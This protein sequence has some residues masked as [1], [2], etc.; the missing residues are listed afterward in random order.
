MQYYEIRIDFYRQTRQKDDFQ[1][2]IFKSI[3]FL[4]IWKAK[5]I[6]TFGMKISAMVVQ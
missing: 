5:I 3:K 6:P 2:W 4:L 1:T